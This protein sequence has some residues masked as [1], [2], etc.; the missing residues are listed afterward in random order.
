MKFVSLAVVGAALVAVW[1]GEVWGQCQDGGGGGQAS[2][3]S[4]G[5]GG[6]IVIAP[7]RLLTGPG[8]WAYD[9]MISQRQS[10][11]YWQQQFALAM[12]QARKKQAEH[13]RRVAYAQQR[14][15]A[16]AY[17][18][19]RDKEQRLAALAKQSR[20]QTAQAR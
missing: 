6:G 14:R 20:V 4:T 3:A 17:R 13:A 5:S 8:S 18:R 16:E 7:A 19:Q 2:T 1:A 9:V 11:A 15:E 12:A 10:Q